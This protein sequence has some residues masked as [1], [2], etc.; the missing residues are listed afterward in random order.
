MFFG[1]KKHYG[2]LAYL[3]TSSFLTTRDFPMKF[4]ASLEVSP[5]ALAYLMISALEGGSNYW[6]ESF[7]TEHSLKDPAPWLNLPI[8]VEYALAPEDDEEPEIEVK[9]IEKADIERALARVATHRDAAYDSS[10]KCFDHDAN[11][12]DDFLQV[13]LLGE[14]V[15]G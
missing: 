1:N 3:P 14:L 7:E 2:M 6:L 9:L 5:Q 11:V 15:Y 12:A 4:Y 10:D 13:L 8:R